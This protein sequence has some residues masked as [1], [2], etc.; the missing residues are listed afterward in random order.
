MCRLGRIGLLIRIGDTPPPPP[1]WDSSIRSS[2]MHKE[3]ALIIEGEINSGRK[4]GLKGPGE[5]RRFAWKE[6]G[7]GEKKKKLLEE[8]QL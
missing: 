2:S 6:A 8:P 3:K 7:K 1:L 4:K 5:T